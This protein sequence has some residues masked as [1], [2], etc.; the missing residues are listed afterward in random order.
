MS[1]FV[2]F[3]I[4]LALVTLFIY[5]YYLRKRRTQQT[6]LWLRAQ[7]VH[8]QHQSGQATVIYPYENPGIH[9]QNYYC[10][11]GL[12]FMPMGFQS[13]QMR[14]QNFEG[15]PWHT[16]VRGDLSHSNV[17]HYVAA[18]PYM[19]GDYIPPSTIEDLPPPYSSVVANDQSKLDAKEGQ[20]DENKT[21]NTSSSSPGQTK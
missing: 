7:N 2:T 14:N 6:L 3:T 18:P 21:D 17:P 19:P 11:S 9:R 12:V 4:L 5:L 8:A 13:A 20:V 1:N 15:A 16:T 10:N